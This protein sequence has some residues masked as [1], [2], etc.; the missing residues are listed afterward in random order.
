NNLVLN[1]KV[2]I[3]NKGTYQSTIIVLFILAMLKNLLFGLLLFI[4][5]LER[6]SIASTDRKKNSQIGR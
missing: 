1:P 6:E 4:N 5:I 3:L 2:E